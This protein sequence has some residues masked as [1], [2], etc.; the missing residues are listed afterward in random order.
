MQI[1]DKPNKAATKAA[2]RDF[3]LAHCDPDLQEAF[4]M[5]SYTVEPLLC[6]LIREMQAGRL[7]EE[8]YAARQRSLADTLSSLVA[9]TGGDYG[10]AP[11]ARAPGSGTDPGED[12]EAP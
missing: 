8:A 12:R 9:A 4:G 6:Q 2:L 7:S 10:A 5:H 3:M 1:I 11:A